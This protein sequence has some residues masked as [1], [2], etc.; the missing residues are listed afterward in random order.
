MIKTMPEDVQPFATTENF[1]LRTAFFQHVFRLPPPHPKPWARA[2]RPNGL[3]AHGPGAGH[4]PLAANPSPKN[5]S[6]F[7]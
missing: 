3:R 5:A 4:L 7:R 2:H 1:I 6:D